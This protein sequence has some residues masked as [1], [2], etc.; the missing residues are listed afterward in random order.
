MNG[1]DLDRPS[2]R[3][4]PRLVY[5]ASYPCRGKQLANQQADELTIGNAASG[6]QRAARSK[7]LPE[8]PA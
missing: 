8:F 5:R 7:V 4:Q 6:K 1:V 3:G 2:L